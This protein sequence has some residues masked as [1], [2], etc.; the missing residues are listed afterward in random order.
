MDENTLR[1]EIKI[2]IH[3]TVRVL[4]RKRMQIPGIIRQRTIEDSD[5]Y[6]ATAI[7][8]A[9][10]TMMSCNILQELIISFEISP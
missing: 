3:N 5:G 9:R 6:P 1:T 8:R 7:G 10:S 4:K 2:S